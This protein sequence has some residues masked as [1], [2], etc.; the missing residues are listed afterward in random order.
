MRPETLTRRE[1]EGY[2]EG[3]DPRVGS[4][5]LRLSEAVRVV[6]GGA[7]R[8]GLAAQAAMVIGSSVASSSCLMFRPT[9]MM[10]VAVII[11][12]TATLKASTVPAV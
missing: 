7:R 10:T 12:P 5:A 3:P 2:D 6:R 4:P 1:D 11:S 8:P 9:R